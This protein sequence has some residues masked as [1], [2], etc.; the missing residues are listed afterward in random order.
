MA[1]VC[2][3][4]AAYWLLLA[5]MGGVALFTA[6]FWI[7]MVID[8]ARSEF[9]NPNDKLVWILIII[10]L[11]FVGALVYWMV[12]KKSAPVSVQK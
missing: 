5:F 4:L 9:K 3:F 2:T 7:S 1:G 10:L 11:H 12:V 8:C 6:V